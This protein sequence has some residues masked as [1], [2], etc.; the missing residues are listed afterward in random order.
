MAGAVSTALRQRPILRIPRR[1]AAD[2]SKDKKPGHS[3]FTLL[4]VDA[5]DRVSLFGKVWVPECIH[6]WPFMPDPGAGSLQSEL[7]LPR[8]HTGRVLR[9]EGDILP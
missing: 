8:L 1:Y 7:P 2:W 9:R 3:S 6:P 4:L 5:V